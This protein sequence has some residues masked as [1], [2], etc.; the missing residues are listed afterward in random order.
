VTEDWEL[1]LREHGFRI[2]PQRQ[3]VLEAVEALR[4]GTPEEILVEVQR[5]ATGVNLSTIYRTLE[6]LE[7][8]GLVTHAHIGHGPP[9]YH[10]VDDEVH[11]HLVCDRC[12]RVQSVPAT[13]ATDFVDRLEA[14]YGFRTDISHVSVH[15]LCDTCKDRDFVPEAD[16]AL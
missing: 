16:D 7:E 13:A 14:D 10:A 3:L 9:T 4:H 6:V 8:V 12:G 15:G 11:I 5:T 2:T 1:R